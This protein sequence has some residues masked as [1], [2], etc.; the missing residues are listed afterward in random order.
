MVDE[1]VRIEEMRLRVPGLSADE[2]HGLGEEVARRVVDGLPGG[3][4]SRRLG[5]LSL[6]VTVPEGTSRDRMAS[7]IAEAILRGVV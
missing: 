2:V 5:A 3:H 4:G 7:L 1:T 6:R